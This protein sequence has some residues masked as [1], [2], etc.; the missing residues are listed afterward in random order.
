MNR[1]SRRL[2]F[3]I[4]VSGFGAICFAPAA[5]AKQLGRFYELE[6]SSPALALAAGASAIHAQRTVHIQADEK[7]LDAIAHRA[8]GVGLN[9]IKAAFPR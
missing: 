4:I 9:Q 8:L 3:A 7:T 6:T 5:G 1:L 2:F